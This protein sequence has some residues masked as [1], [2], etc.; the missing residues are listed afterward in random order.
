MLGL[1]LSSEDLLTL[2][3]YLDQ[4]VERNLS[5]KQMVMALSTLLD[6]PEKVCH[7]SLHYEEY[8]KQW[9]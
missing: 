8:W 1:V 4:Y 9:L 6:T 3:Y 7:T 5:I 2:N